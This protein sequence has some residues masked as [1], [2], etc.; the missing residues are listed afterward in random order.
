MRRT[1]RNLYVVLLVTAAAIAQPTI[2]GLSNTAAARSSRL[3]LQGSGFGVAQGS[4]T[5]Q[6]AGIAA[7][8]TR[9]SDTFIAAYV[10]ETAP[11]G[12]DHVQVITSAGSSNAV[13]INVTLR[14]GP[15]GHIRWRFQADGDYIA[16]RPAIAVD[17]TVYTQDLYGHL[18]ALAS[19]GGLKWIFNAPGT[20]HDAI[21][22][23][24]EG[25]IYIGNTSSIFAL[26]PNGTVRWRFEQNPPAFILLGPNVG[27]DGNIYA[28]GT[29]GM[30]VFSLTPQGVLRW[31]LTENYSRPIVTQQE[32]IFGPLLQSRLYFH[33]N[34]HLRGVALD[35]SQ[36]FT[37]VDHLD[38]AEGLQQPVVAPDG[39]V[40]SNLFT[41][42]GP[43]VVLGK[44]DRNGNE[45]WHIFDQLST[46]TNVVSAPDVGSNGVVYDGQNLLNLYAINP[47]GSIRWKYTD[48]ETLFAPIVSPLNDVVFMGGATNGQPGFFEAVSS[49]GTRLWKSSLPIENGL[50]VVPMSRARF[51]P[52]GLTAY[53]GTSI[54]GQVSDGY[55]YLYSVQVGNGG[56]NSVSLSALT[57]NPTTVK[58]GTSSRGTVTLTGPAPAGGIVV[59]LA[60]NRKAATVP[61]SVTIPSGASSALFT[62]NTKVVSLKK[63]ATISATYQ[64]VTKSAK[65]TLLP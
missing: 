33:A 61:P 55:S 10:P 56:G 36:S 15:S 16:T 1:V 37:F 54:P 59:T 45:L 20:G 65:L 53:I 8:V 64:G 13:P 12:T 46:S 5:V 42:P 43:G 58:S 30:G 41:Y 47:D 57:L 26:A 7:P 29:Q 2:T 24:S 18:Y 6:I 52:D 21:S 39:S 38:T 3:L 48:T 63:I 49:A 50:N 35:G 17:G 34:D 27:P 25:T 22:L 44:F 23:G 32:I 9:W 51:T 11:T 60:S 62:V 14:P 19:D 28:V 40:Y 4:A 31:S